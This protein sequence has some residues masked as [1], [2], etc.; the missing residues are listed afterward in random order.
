MPAVSALVRVRQEDFREF[1]PAG[2]HTKTLYLRKR[3][4]QGKHLWYTQASADTKKLEMGVYIGP[5]KS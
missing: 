3:E 1:K 4:G 2:L 5:L